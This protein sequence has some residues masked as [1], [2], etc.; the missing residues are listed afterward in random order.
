MSTREVCSRRD[1]GSAS[2]GGIVFMET[3]CSQG[4]HSPYREL[5]SPQKGHCGTEYPW[6]HRNLRRESTHYRAGQFTV[7]SCVQIHPAIVCF[8]LRGLGHLPTTPAPLLWL[9]HSSSSHHSL[10]LPMVGPPKCPRIWLPALVSLASLL[11]PLHA[12]QGLQSTEL[13]TQLLRCH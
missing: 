3:Q 13:P 7:V 8:F 11:W 10:V 4:E 5:L 12:L 6:Q 1:R 9:M 2:E